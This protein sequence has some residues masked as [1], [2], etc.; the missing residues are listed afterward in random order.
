MHYQDSL[1]P[2]V[3][4]T[5]MAFLRHFGGKTQLAG[6]INDA[7]DWGISKLG[8]VYDRRISTFGGGAPVLLQ[9]LPL[10][11]EVYNDLDPDTTNV[12]Q[13]FKINSKEVID[14]ILAEPISE[15]QFER[16]EAK[17]FYDLEPENAADQAAAYWLYCRYSFNGGGNQWST[18]ISRDRI[19]R[20][21]PPDK[22]YLVSVADRVR[23]WVV[24]SSDFVDCISQWS[25]PSSVFYHDPPYPLE[26]RLSRDSRHLQGSPTRRYL[27]ELGATE[28]EDTARHQELARL[29]HSTPGLHATSGYD[30]PLYQNLYRD[31]VCFKQQTR[32]SARQDRVEHLW[33]IR[34]Y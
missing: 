23:D 7:I 29:V 11:I 16:W 17:I 20:L 4:R 6:W 31:A 18:G 12:F 34:I 14:R 15:E 26:S 9:A 5:D 8:G 28:E 24:Q 10:G 30:C 32:D 25:S 13:Q 22:K 2:L 3:N 21:S 33:L 19:R 1:I 27:H